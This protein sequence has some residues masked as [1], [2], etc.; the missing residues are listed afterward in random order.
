M[1][2]R[3]SLG[4]KNPANFRT[5]EADSIFPA[6]KLNVHSG[7]NSN[8]ITLSKGKAPTQRGCYNS[9]F[10]EI[11]V[12]N[13]HAP[14]PQVCREFP[15]IRVNN[16]DGVFLV[17]KSRSIYYGWRPSG[18]LQSSSISHRRGAFFLF[19]FVNGCHMLS[20]ITKILHLEPLSNLFLLSFLAPLLL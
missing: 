2:D 20:S 19:F 16:S 10:H 7:L 11:S 15:K 5:L 12:L 3:Q 4:E 8:L 9:L 1:G 17:A 6:V 18:P 14:K 13:S